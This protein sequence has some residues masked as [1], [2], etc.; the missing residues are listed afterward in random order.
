MDILLPALIVFS[1]QL[2][3]M[4]GV[5]AIAEALGRVSDPRLGFTYWRGV[6]LAC[7][8]LPLSAIAGPEAHGS[9][10]T[11][12]VSSLV[13]S[14]ED[15][16][17]GL[18]PVRA[19][20]PAAAGGIVWGL[21]CAGAVARLGW[22]CAGAVR[23]RQL[24]QRSRA[25]VLTSDLEAIRSDVAPRAEFRVSDDVSQPVCFGVRRPIVLLPADFFAMDPQAQRT[26][27]CHELLHVARRDWAWIVVEE[28]TRALFWF[29]P[30][31]WWLVERIQESREQL[32]DRLVIARIPSKRAYMSAL[33]A[34]A[35][36]GRP[37]VLA[38]A[39]LRRRH[40]RSRLR[41]L[42]KESVMSRGRLISTAVVLVAV[43]GGAMATTVKALP[44]DSR[45]R[46]AGAA[47][48]AAV[49]AQAQDVVDGKAPGVTLPK[50]VTEVNPKYTPEAM[51][52]RIQGSL[53]VSAIV[54]TDGTPRDV[55]ITRSLD[56]QYGLDK[57]AVAAL[58]QWRFEPGL[59]DGKPVPVRITVLMEFR[60]GNPPK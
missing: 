11:F 52:A 35:D 45:L 37:A 25:V 54:R 17:A 2:F 3:V 4:I 15:A 21:L 57:E 47:G 8:A 44:F 19:V 23:L 49:P 29:H 39:F 28:V 40:L 27:A 46:A 5:A 48:A 53:E 41:K 32:V 51:Q 1:A 38:T 50:V 12:L 58:T 9:G 34:F 20:L 22:L 59:K 30:A 31:V 36:G 43:M 6:A 13:A 10:V 55:K 56:E 7:L 16:G 24:R 26:V 33:L 14:V 18:G 60:L 42:A